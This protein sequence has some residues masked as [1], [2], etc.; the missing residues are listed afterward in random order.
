MSS[1]LLEKLSPPADTE[2]LDKE[3]GSCDDLNSLPSTM[4]FNGRLV[5]IN[6]AGYPPSQPNK[7]EGLWDFT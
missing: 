7:G 2:E 6:E 5:M 4:M 3:L 1:K